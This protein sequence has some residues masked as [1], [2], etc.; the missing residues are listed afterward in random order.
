MT[1]SLKYL[2]MLV[3][4]TQYKKPYFAPVLSC[5][6]IWVLH[7]SFQ[8]A[9]SI[10]KHLWNKFMHNCEHPDCSFFVSFNYSCKRYLLFPS[11]CNLPIS[12]ET[13]VHRKYSKLTW[14]YK[15]WFQH[16]RCHTQLQLLTI[17]QKVQKYCKL[18][19]SLAKSP[20][21]LRQ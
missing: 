4:Q 20:P 18:I 15:K 21:M 8:K 19:V 9:L 10:F 1:A 3:F 14:Y 2:G 13:G 16:F 7:C 12:D 11:L 6:L 17:E 5:H